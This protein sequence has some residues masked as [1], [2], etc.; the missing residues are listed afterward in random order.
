MSNKIQAAIRAAYGGLANTEVLMNLYPLEN[1]GFA[2]RMQSDNPDIVAAVT[3][4]N[5]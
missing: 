3:Q 2:G 1:A 4:L 5:S